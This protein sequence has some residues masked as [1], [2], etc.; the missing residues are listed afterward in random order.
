ME[1][2]VSC[3]VSSWVN[4]WLFRRCFFNKARQGN[5]AQTEKQV[6]E[7]LAQQAQHHIHQTR[8]KRALKASAKP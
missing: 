2:L 7:I 5:T 3:F 1:L 4:Y 8:Q 6:K